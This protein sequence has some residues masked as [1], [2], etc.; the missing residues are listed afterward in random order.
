L[1]T[2]FF[3]WIFLAKKNN[4][5][6][7]QKYYPDGIFEAKCFAP[8]AKRKTKKFQT[9]ISN[10]VNDNCYEFIKP[11]LVREIQPG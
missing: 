2:N 3:F 1:A 9:V 8:L 6:A 11:F 5:Q 7:P 4:F 10:F